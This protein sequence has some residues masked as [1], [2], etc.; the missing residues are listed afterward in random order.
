MLS[1]S[2]AWGRSG[3]SSIIKEKN[4]GILFLSDPCTRILNCPSEINMAISVCIF[5]R[6]LC[7][8][9]PSSVNYCCVWRMHACT[10]ACVCVL[11]DHKLDAII[12]ARRF[13]HRISLVNHLPNVRLST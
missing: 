12:I 1:R 6:F 10:Y 8:S 2:S 7:G 4:S 13:F 3:N 5:S 9:G 11:E